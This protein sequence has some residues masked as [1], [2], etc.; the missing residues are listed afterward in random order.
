MIFFIQRE[1]FPGTMLASEW[2]KY[3]LAWSMCIKYLSGKS[4]GELSIKGEVA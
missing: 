3:Q 2:L 4:F 1:I